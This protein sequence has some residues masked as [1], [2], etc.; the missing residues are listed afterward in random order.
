MKKSTPDTQLRFSVSV[1]GELATL[2]VNSTGSRIY[3]CIRDLKARFE[4]VLAVV[5]RTVPYAK[6]LKISLL[7]M[8]PLDAVLGV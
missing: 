4:K 7:T 8:S 6:K 2:H 5:S 3:K 1:I